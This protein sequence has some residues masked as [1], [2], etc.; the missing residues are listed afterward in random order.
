LR[1]RRRKKSHLVSARRRPQPNEQP[2]SQTSERSPDHLDPVVAHPTIR[3]DDREVVEIGLR[4]E[5]AVEG[6]AVVHGSVP[7]LPAPAA[8]RRIR[9]IRAAD[10]VTLPVA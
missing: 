6:I 8:T 2:N 1:S 10:G 4:D 5:Q 7:G 9:T 3:A